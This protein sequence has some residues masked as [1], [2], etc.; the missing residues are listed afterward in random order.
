M[1]DEG[2]CV[3]KDT[4]AATHFFA[5]AADLG[6]QDAALDYAAKVG[7]GDGTQQSYERAGELCRAAGLDSQARLSAYSL[8]YACT[9]RGVAGELLRATLPKGAFRP[10]GGAALVEFNP[11]N[12]EMQ[13]R[14]TPQVGFAD[15]RTGSNVHNPLV[16]ARQE[17][18]KAWR[19]AVAAAPPP[20]AAQLDHQTIELSLDVERTIEVGREAA[21]D[22]DSLRS[23]HQGEVRPAAQR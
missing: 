8:G 2:I 10:G 21:A 14:A 4:V 6:D 11:T 22:T 20:D 5:R 15:A 13:V 23:L 18:G 16:D 3:Q 7:L 19:A 17:I 9:L 12:A 1:L